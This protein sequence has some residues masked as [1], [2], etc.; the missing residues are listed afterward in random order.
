M[1]TARRVSGA[2]LGKTRSGTE[3]PLSVHTRVRTWEPLRRR[4]SPPAFPSYEAVD[5]PDGEAEQDHRR[6]G[7]AYAHRGAVA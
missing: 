7:D 6:D 3:P 4:R 1:D 2:F 5:E